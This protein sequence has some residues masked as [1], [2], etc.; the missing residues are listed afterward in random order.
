MTRRTLLSGLFAKNKPYG[1]AFSFKGFPNWPLEKSFALCAELGYSGV[2]LFVGAKQ[3]HE[4]GKLGVDEVR[5]LVTKHKL[6][7]QTLM[8][9]LRLTG[10][11]QTLQ[12]QHLEASLKLARQIDPKR[13]PLI[14]TVVGGRND[15]WPKL[16][17]IFEERLKPWAALAEK[18][19]VVIAIKPHIGSALHLPEDGAALCDR[20]NS[21]YLKLN[22]DY[23]HFQLQ[24]LDLKQSIRAAL[25][26][27]AMIHIKDSIGKPP[28]FRFA[29][30]GEG[31]ID[32]KSYVQIL[33]QL[34][35]RDPIVVEV[36]SQVI[37]QPNYN[38][39]QAA[40]QVAT[41]VLPIFRGRT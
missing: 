37:A 7:V 34:N 41:T 1:L 9:D 22:Y 33:H 13:S 15:E 18:Y 30:P 8:E 2:E 28:K 19:K 36:S 11:D 10:E 24:N 40:K 21:R 5:R 6:P 39:E 35:Y 23:S 27:I 29:L 17:P 25:P 4:P 32:Y 3:S 14:E 26:H 16:K 38:P 31:T 12:L 20:I